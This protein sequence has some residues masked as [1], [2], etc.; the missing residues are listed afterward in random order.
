M[1]R[2]RRSSPSSNATAFLV[3]AEPHKMVVPKS[4]RTGVVVEPMLTDQWFVKTEGLA[5]SGLDAVA[6]GDVKFYPDHW[7]STYNHWLENIQDWCISRQLWWG[8]QIPAWYDDGGNIYVARNEEEAKKASH[9]QGPWRAAQARRRRARHVV[10][11]RAGAVLLARLAGK[12]PGSRHLPA[13]LGAGDG[14]RH[15][16]LLGRPDDHDDAAFHRQGAVP[17]RVHQ[18]AGEGRGRAEDVQVQRQHARP[19]RSHRRHLGCRT[20]LPNRPWGSCAPTTSRRSK[21]T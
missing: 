13:L 18:C 6:K 7:A 16:L 14:V 11:L 15:H 8:H 17:P 5:K 1:T 2:A 21:G 9:R 12:N 20:C 4:G 19:A 10:F 3:A